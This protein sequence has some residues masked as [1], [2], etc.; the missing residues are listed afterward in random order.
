M[1]ADIMNKNEQLDFVVPEEGSNLWFDNL[2][3]PKTA[4]NELVLIISK[5]G[6]CF[7]QRPF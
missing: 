2:V 4:H 7:S 1:A 6:H 3:I 5:K